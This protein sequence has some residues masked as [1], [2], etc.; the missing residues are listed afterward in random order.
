MKNKDIKELGAVFE[1]LWASADFT[2]VLEFTRSQM[3]KINN[4]ILNMR[5]REEKD[6]FDLAT[7]Q[8]ELSGVSMM[9]AHVGA[10]IKLKRDVELKEAK[11]NKKDGKQPNLGQTK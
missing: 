6:M 9:E 2:K 1:R 8:G 4:E 11:E 3:S 10:V 5:V 7:K